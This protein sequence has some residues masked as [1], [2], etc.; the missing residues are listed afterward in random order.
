MSPLRGPLQPPSC[1]VPQLP[2][3]WAMA[4]IHNP[5]LSST[6]GHKVWVGHGRWIA[7]SYGFFQLL[8]YR[9]ALA[10]A[11]VCTWCH[12]LGASRWAFR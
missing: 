12:H 3:G 2:E 1:C 4:N 5:W 8:I 11:I 9:R 6:V 10:C 7:V